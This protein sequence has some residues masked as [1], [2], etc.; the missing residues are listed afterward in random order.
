MNKLLPI[1]LYWKYI[2]DKKSCKNIATELKVSQRTIFNR[3][4]E[5]KIFKSFRGQYQFDDWLEK[6]DA[7]TNTNQ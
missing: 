7:R 6:Y 4:K 5:Y 2:V 3:L 1:E